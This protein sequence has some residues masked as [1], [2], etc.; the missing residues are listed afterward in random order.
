MNSVLSKSPI[1]PGVLNPEKRENN[2]SNA[3]KNPVKAIIIIVKKIKIEVSINFNIL[4]WLSLVIDFS[5]VIS[6]CFKMGTF[7]K[8]DL[9]I[10]F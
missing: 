5:L 8:K 3:I 10:F 7:S 1:K 2:P 6:L 4:F 9:F